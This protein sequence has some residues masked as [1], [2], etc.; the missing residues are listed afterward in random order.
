VERF[1]HQ[2]RTGR[3]APA[4][5]P[6]LLEKARAIY[7][8]RREREKLFPGQTDLFSDPAWDILLDLFAAYETGQRVSISSACIA[9]NVPPT[10]ALRWLAILENRGLIVRASDDTD[11]RRAFVRLS[12]L[13][14]KRMSQWLKTWL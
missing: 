11:K 6:P 5:G 4:G 12:D 1:R 2:D 3:A 7:R 9:S 14:H 13:T 10:T 8:A